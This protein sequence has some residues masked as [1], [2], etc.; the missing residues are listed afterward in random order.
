MV[1]HTETSNSYF[2]KLTLINVAIYI[3]IAY[4]IKK[5]KLK[6][7]KIKFFPIYNP[8]PLDK[9]IEQLSE[10]DE[11]ESE[12]KVT[13][14]NQLKH[15]LKSLDKIQTTDKLQMRLPFDIKL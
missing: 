3:A 2:K 6:N 1:C 11:N 13:L 12:S 9:L 15:H 4:A 10:L 7:P 5:A 8:K 14:S